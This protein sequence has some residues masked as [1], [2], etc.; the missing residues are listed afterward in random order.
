MPSGVPSSCPGTVRA[1]AV[2]APRHLLVAAVTDSMSVRSRPHQGMRHDAY[3]SEPPECSSSAPMRGDDGG[4]L[5]GPSDPLGAN[6]TRRDSGNDVNDPEPTCT[7]QD[8]C[9]AN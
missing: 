7:V 1:K 8:F 2:P 5:I 6:R 4:G 9:N 3:R